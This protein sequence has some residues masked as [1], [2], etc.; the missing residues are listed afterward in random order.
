LRLYDRT[1]RRINVAHRLARAAVWGG[2]DLLVRALS[3]A[4]GFELPAEDLLPLHRLPL[5]LGAYERETMAVCRRLLTPGAVAVDVGAHAG[6]FTIAFARLTGPAGRVVA[7]EPHPQTCAILRRNVRRRRLAHVVIEQQAVSDRE[8]EAVFYETAWSMG[9]TL[10][11]VKE[12]VARMVVATTSL[13]A[14]LLR[15]GI[16]NVA[17]VKV[18]AEG[19]EPEV[20]AGLEV[21]AARDPGPSLVLEFKPVLLERRG[22]Q[23]ARLLARLTDMGFAVYA[24]RR[25]G[26]LWHVSAGQFDRFVR[27]ARPGNILAHKGHPPLPVRDWMV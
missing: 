11:P 26:M 20:V 27:L 9:H 18:D 6:Y 21:T 4:R 1:V 10:Q 23:P 13:D 5:L 22:F 2:G 17:L 15:A 16:T 12:H 25:G 7:F 19:G 3:R 14:Y 24:L 8:G